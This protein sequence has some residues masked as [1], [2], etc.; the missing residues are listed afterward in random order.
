ML[1]RFGIA[2][3]LAVMVTLG[4]LFTMQVLIAQPQ[5]KLDKSGTKHFVDFVRVQREESVQRTERRREKPV[6]P[7][8]PPQQSVQPRV[9]A[10]NENQMSVSIPTAPLD[11]GVAMSITGLGLA[12]SDGEYLPLV[13]I[14]PIYPAAAQS[15]GIEGSCM[16]EYTVTTTGTVRDVKVIEA[17]P[18]GIFNKV[19]IAAAKKSKY[20]PR[21][22][23]GEP[24]EV[25]GVRTVYYFK[26]ER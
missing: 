25:Y 7:D 19:S 3:V 6:A 20:R 21:V 26:R 5:A 17:T 18:A 16:V 4:V 10:L 13:K 11:V 2:T 15:R 22:V 9:D 14:E 1:A 24:I 23:D 8:A 12:A